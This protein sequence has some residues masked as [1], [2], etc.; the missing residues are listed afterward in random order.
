MTR[1]S[2]P[3]PR[4]L[5]AAALLA[6]VPAAGAQDP[7]KQPTRPA[8]TT[9]DVKLIDDSTVKL[10]LLDG[11]LEFLTP[12]G[13]L[14]IPV[15]EIRKVELGLRIPD[16]VA[17]QIQAAVADLGSNQFRKR[18][19]ATALLLRYR[20]KSYPALKQAAKHEKRQ[21]PRKGAED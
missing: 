13:K 3:A 2:A 5:A 20:E 11:Q 19:E 18:E 16:D 15:A 6:L 17:A 9:I 21:G 1:R 7:K 4:L 12:H 8:E 14:V 10:T